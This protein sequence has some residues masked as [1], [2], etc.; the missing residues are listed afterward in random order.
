MSHVLWDPQLTLEVTTDVSHTAPNASNEVSAYVR[1]VLVLLLGRL[2][3][4]RYTVTDGASVTGPRL[5]KTL[6]ARGVRVI[7]TY[8]KP[9][10][11]ENFVSIRSRQVSQEWSDSVSDE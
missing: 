4:L 6:S 7:S 1:T 5:K 2:S 11:R 10:L 8:G 3:L 9:S